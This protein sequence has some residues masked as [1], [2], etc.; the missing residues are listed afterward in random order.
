MIHCFTICK[1][2]ITFP[3]PL[4]EKYRRFLLVPTNLFRA[5]LDMFLHHERSIASKFGQPLLRATRALSPIKHDSRFI[6]VSLVRL[7]AGS[8]NERSVSF[9]HCFK[10]RI[11]MFSQVWNR[12][13]T[14]SSAIQRQFSRRIAFKNT[15][16]RLAKF[17]T[18]LPLTSV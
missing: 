17:S 18:T 11:S 6:V 8:L 10:L 9:K 4:Q 2:F 12:V 15:L 1:I 5:S 16:Q 3:S 14:E 13:F 7:C